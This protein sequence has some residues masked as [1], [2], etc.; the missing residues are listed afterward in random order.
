MIEGYAYF[1]PPP[2]VEGIWFCRRCMRNRPF[3]TTLANAGHNVPDTP[4][5]CVECDW[6][7]PRQAHVVYCYPAPPRIETIPMATNVREAGRER[8][9]LE[10]VEMA[11]AGAEMFEAPS[12]AT[13]SDIEIQLRQIAGEKGRRRT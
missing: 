4:L 3:Q 1:E 5:Y 6:E 8:W 9:R 2:A 12:I 10:L 11:L 13:P 7:I